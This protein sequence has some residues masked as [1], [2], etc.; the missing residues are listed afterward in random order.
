MI[1]GENSR[2]QDIDVN[3]CREKKM[4][5]VRSKNKDENTVLAPP[6]Q[7]TIETALDFIDGDEL[8]EVTPDAVRIRK[9]ILASNMRPKR[10]DERLSG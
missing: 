8:V 7:H 1:V 6:V 10:N 2:P 3:V 5:N 9:K 4:T